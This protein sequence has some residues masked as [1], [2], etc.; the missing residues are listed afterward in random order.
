MEKKLTIKEN[1]F[2]G[3]IRENPVL[4]LLLG[5]CPTL[6]VTSSATNAIG[7]GLATTFVLVMS[8]MAISMVKNVVPDKVRIPAYIVIIA[9]FVTVV[10]LLMEAYTPALFAQ[11][12]LFIPLI[13]VNCIVLGRAE[14][15]ASR[16]SVGDSAIDGLGMGMGFTLALLL[17]GSIREVLGSLS[18]FGMKFSES[19]GMLVFVLAP[20]A[21]LTLGF[22]IAIMNGLKK[23]SKT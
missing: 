23:R 11:L 1:L 17:L 9:A 16:N 4:A 7:M 18:W 20:G 14:A 12:G 13:V 6:G 8:N 19:D 3:L 2:K 10:Q 21:F 15:F 5:C 22:L